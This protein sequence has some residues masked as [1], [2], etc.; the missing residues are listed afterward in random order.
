MDD[1]VS[2]RRT[3]V[4]LVMGVGA[5]VRAAPFAFFCLLFVA[6]SAG[7]T[8]FGVAAAVALAI[9]VAGAATG[10]VMLALHH[11]GGRTRAATAGAAL[12]V[13]VTAGTAGLY[14][15][16]SSHVTALVIAATAAWM[17]LRMPI[18]RWWMNRPAAADMTRPEHPRGFRRGPEA[19]DLQHHPADR[20]ASDGTPRVTHLH[21]PPYP[22]TM[23]AKS[24]TSS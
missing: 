13:G 5:A 19:P 7:S 20:C 17:I 10:G 9:L 22:Q 2:W 3:V 23:L 14:E 24:A 21:R 16:A 4:A 11:F 15:D 1:V 12:G 6:L 8:R 18:S